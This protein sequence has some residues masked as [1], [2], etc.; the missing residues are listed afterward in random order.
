MHRLIG[1]AVA[2]VGQKRRTAAVIGS[3]AGIRLC[4]WYQRVIVLQTTVA[5]QMT[6][7]PYNFQLYQAGLLGLAGFIGATIG[8][9]FGGW[10][11]DMIANRM[12]I[13][14]GGIRRPTRVRNG[15]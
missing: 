8:I 1:W 15:C 4:M 12:T 7:P 2:R 5:R 11:C 9:F 10:L 13:R 14:R 6:L 3:P